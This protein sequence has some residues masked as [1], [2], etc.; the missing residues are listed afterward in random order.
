[1]SEVPAALVVEDLHKSF[2]DLEVLKQAK[3]EVHERAMALLEKVGI[4][5]KHAA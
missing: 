3:Q 4:A 5:G 1:M 2:G